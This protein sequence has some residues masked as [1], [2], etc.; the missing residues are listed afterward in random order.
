MDIVHKKRSKLFLFYINKIT[1]IIM[2]L[3]TPQIKYDSYIEL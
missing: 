1:V 3:V 2:K